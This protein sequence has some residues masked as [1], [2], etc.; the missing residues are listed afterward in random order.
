MAHQPRVYITSRAERAESLSYVAHTF[1][2][3]VR[4][5]SWDLRGIEP[6]SARRPGDDYARCA[7]QAHYIETCARL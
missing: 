4:S 1:S 7:R 3:A 6:I 2:G 5:G